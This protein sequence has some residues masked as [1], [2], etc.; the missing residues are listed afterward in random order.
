MQFSPA[1]MIVYAIIC[2]LVTIKFILWLQI[3][4]GGRGSFLLSFIMLASVHNIHDASTI[5]SKRFLKANNTINV[6]IWLC[7]AI[8]IIIF[9]K[10]PPP[11]DKPPVWDPK[12][13][14]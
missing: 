5:E 10:E 4:K 6:L 3:T 8:L 1:E 2:L 7:I 11:A 14:F 12:S 13:I 9:I